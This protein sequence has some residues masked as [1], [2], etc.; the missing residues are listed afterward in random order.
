LVVVVIL[1]VRYKRQ[2]PH[3]NSGDEPESIRGAHG[4]RIQNCEGEMK[5]KR[6]WDLKEQTH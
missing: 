1:V 6:V 5:K 2:V 4:F 3:K